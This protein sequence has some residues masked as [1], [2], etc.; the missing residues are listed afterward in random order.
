PAQ[1][2]DHGRGH[3]A[4]VARALGQVGV[5]QGGEH[6]GLGLGG[7]SDGGDALGSGSHRVDR[8]ADQGGVR[9]DERAD[10][11]DAGLEILTA[12][13]QPGP[14]E[15]AGPLSPCMET[16]AAAPAGGASGR[17]ERGA[18]CGAPSAIALLKALVAVASASTMVLAPSRAAPSCWTP[19]RAASSAVDKAG[20]STSAAPPS[21][22]PARRNAMPYS[23][24]EAPPTLEIRVLPVRVKIAPGVVAAESSAPS[25]AVNPRERLMPWSASPIAASSCV[26]WSRLAS[27]TPAADTIQARKTSASMM[28]PTSRDSLV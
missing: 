20:R 24:P 5:G 7:R 27:I 6:G 4:D 3:L 9:R 11:H 19:A 1:M 15:P 14:R 26:R 8:R 18:S 28:A 22:L 23:G 12:P 25:T 10:V 2:I 13:A 21:A 16:G 17:T